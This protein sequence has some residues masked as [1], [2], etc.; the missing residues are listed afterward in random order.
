MTCMPWRPVL[1]QA[2][3]SADIMWRLLVTRSCRLP[4][5]R[6]AGT[7]SCNF[8]PV[9]RTARDLESRVDSLP[10]VRRREQK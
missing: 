6:V 1:K 3:V 4:A 2:A 8:K 7:K 10:S 5:H 9:R